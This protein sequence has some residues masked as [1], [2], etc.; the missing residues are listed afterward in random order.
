MEKRLSYEEAVEI[1]CRYAQRIYSE[2]D[3]QAEVYLY[4]SIA[5]DQNHPK[6]DIDLAVVSKV[7][8][9][10][11]CN[12]YAIVNFLAFD[13]DD[14]IDAQA[15]IYDDWINMTPFTAEVKRQGVL[16]A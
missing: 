4:G 5:R 15:I 16:I 2:L 9:N 7:F 13:I 8:T 1:A 12:N 10:D 11:V 14:K 3:S 6:S